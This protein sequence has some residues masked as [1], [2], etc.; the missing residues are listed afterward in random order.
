MYI[1][2]DNSYNSQAVSRILMI[3]GI[4][5]SGNTGPL[6]KKNYLYILDIN[7]QD[8]NFMIERFKCCTLYK[9]CMNNSKYIY[10]KFFGSLYFE[11]ENW[12]NLLWFDYK[13]N[14]RNFHVKLPFEVIKCV[15]GSSVAKIDYE[16]KLS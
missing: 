13:L 15:L 5:F 2:F 7:R 3:S 4:I 12:Y 16:V 9:V 8:V 6:K 1:H 14:K 11:K 10:Q